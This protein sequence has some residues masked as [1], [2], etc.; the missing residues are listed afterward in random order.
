[1][2]YAFIDKHKSIWPVSV[3]CEQLEISPRGY[4]QLRQ[5]QTVSPVVASAAMRSWRISKRSMCSSTENMVGR[6]CGKSF[7]PMVF[8]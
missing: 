4:H 7:W 8:V 5:R 6:V 2:K 3:L 1:M